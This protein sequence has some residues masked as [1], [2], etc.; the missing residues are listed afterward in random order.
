[1]AADVCAF[2][3]QSTVTNDD[4]DVNNVVDALVANALTFAMVQS[5]QQNQQSVTLK[6]FNKSTKS[7]IKTFTTLFEIYLNANSN[8]LISRSVR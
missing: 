5:Q 4:D 2:D 7:T 1:M 3:G 6:L 8:E